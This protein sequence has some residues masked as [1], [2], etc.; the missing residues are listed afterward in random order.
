MIFVSLK[1]EI[2]KPIFE[3]SESDIID[4]I[5]NTPITLD[6]GKS[7]KEESDRINNFYAEEAKLSKRIA[8]IPALIDF[9][10]LYYVWNYDKEAPVH[11]LPMTI[12]KFNMITE[13]MQ[14]PKDELNEC[15]AQCIENYFIRDV[16]IENPPFMLRTEL[17]PAEIKEKIKI[18]IEPLCKDIMNKLLSKNTST[19]T[20]KTEI[21]RAEQR[22]DNLQV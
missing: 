5:H 19:S 3:K 11:K 8:T 14:A 4:E 22:P 20:L 2:E 6:L 18:I 1:K 12:F 13:A 9:A 10:Y 21:P 17:S 15:F 7:I 16:R